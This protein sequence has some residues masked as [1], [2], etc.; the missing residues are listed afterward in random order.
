VVFIFRITKNAKQTGI[1]WSRK[2]WAPQG[3][4]AHMCTVAMQHSQMHIQKQHQPILC[5]HWYIDEETKKQWSR[6]G[7]LYFGLL[8]CTPCK[9]VKGIWKAYKSI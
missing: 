7:S 2:Q 9:H 1:Y 5:T 4:A 3:L 6:D 8:K